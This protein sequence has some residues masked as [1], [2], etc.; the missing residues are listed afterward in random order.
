MTELSPFSWLRRLK[1]HDLRPRVFAIPLIFFVAL[2]ITSLLFPG[3]FLDIAT[4]LNTA[5]LNLFT[6]GFTIAAFCFLLTCLW[7]ALSPLGKVKIGGR[8]AVPILSRWNWMAITLTTTVAIGIL[9][10]ATAEPI[11]HLS[12][13]GGLNMLPGGEE[14]SR[15]ALSSLY[16]HWSFTPY[17]IYTV[18]G[19]AFALAYHNLRYP[20][21]LASPIR[22]ITGRRLPESIRDILD[23]LALL[24]LLFGLSASLGAGILSLAGGLDRVLGVG[25]GAIVT[26]T[27]TA[28]VVGGFAISSASGLQRGI[29]LLSDINTRIFIAFLL[30]VLIAGPT[31]QI[32]MMGLQALSDYGAGFVSRSLLLPPY[33]DLDWAKAWT[34][35]YWANW[36]AWAPLS[37]MFL[38]RISRGYTVRAYILVNLVLPA[39]FSILWMT[40]FGGF[41]LSIEA[42]QPGTL[43][44]V[45]RNGGPEHV[46]YAVLDL[47]PM[48]GL[49]AGF[50]VIL[51]YLS[52]VTAAD[53][54][55]SVLAQLSA[56]ES[57][58]DPSAP[59]PRRPIIKIIY[60]SAVGLAAWSMVTLSGIDGVR[61]LSNLGGLPALFIVSAFNLSLIWMG[62]RG[63]K[64]LNEA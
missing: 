10:W 42:D 43:A 27:V 63:L 29:R 48:G 15:F 33:D 4:R 39:I 7:A 38:G 51:T 19:L 32:L 6:H 30:F 53:S 59:Q 62:T 36:L 23:G 12:E 25:T 34:V 41:A 46:L 35:F 54:N 14:A 26:L 47:L 58:A 20:F 13:P 28:L 11:Y 22:A 5:I 60:A 3:P 2:I 24:A 1:D 9:F 17:A 49:L 31:G 37:A 57:Q 45:L 16:L 8:D 56:A 55:T 64:T 61:M 21:S 52:Y 40:I 44:S 50:V 18:P